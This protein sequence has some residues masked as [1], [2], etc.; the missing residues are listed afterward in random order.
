VGKEVDGE[1]VRERQPSNARI[2]RE[3]ARE[4]G[5]GR[6]IERHAARRVMAERARSDEERESCRC[7]ST[8]VRCHRRSEEHASVEGI[9]VWVN[10]SE[11]ATRSEAVFS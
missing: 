6:S 9:V 7:R 1:A 11:A 10:P 2:D 3:L 8:E 5:G 4:V